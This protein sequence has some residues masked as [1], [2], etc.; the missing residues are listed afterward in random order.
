MAGY[1]GF[2]SF[3][4]DN[5]QHLLHATNYVA[6]QLP[7]EVPSL[8]PSASPHAPMRS[9]FLLDLAHWT[10][11]NHGAFG[12][13]FA[14][15]QAIADLWRHH[16]ET[17]PLRLMDRYVEC[18]YMP[19][20]SSPTPMP[21]GASCSPSACAAYACFSRT[22]PPNGPCLAPQRHHRHQCRASQ[23]RASRGRCVFAG[24]WVWCCQK[25]DPGCMCSG[26]CDACGRM[27]AGWHSS[28]VR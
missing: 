12:A 10:F 26:W 18:Y 16:T 1:Q 7:F 28:D 27:C 5:V 20:K 13:P 17:Q 4:S 11:I 22:L 19:I 21:Q 14:H 25:D 15:A 24:H 2:G 9:H 8:N 3:H 23:C 6:P